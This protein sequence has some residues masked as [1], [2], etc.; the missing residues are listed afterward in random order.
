MSLHGAQLRVLLHLPRVAHHER[1]DDRRP[2]EPGEDAVPEARVRGEAR[3]LLGD[4]DGE[5]VEEGGREARGRPEERDAGADDRVV[6]EVA[7]QRNEDD[8][9]GN[10]AFGHAEDGTRQ[11]ERDHEGG[12]H[13]ALEGGAAGHGAREPRDAELHG[14][15]FLQDVEAPADDEEEGDEERP[16]DEALDGGEEERLGTRGRPSRPVW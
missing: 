10:H 15:R 14:S 12:D 11:G 1:H 9:E 3:E 6:A 8:D 4:P 16:F 5:G 7:R 13:E 2:D